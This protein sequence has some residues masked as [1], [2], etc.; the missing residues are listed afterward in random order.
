M[1]N[2]NKSWPADDTEY[3]FKN[4]GN[5]LFC[6]IYQKHPKHPKPKVRLIL[7]HLSMWVSEDS[8]SA[9]HHHSSWGTGS[10][11][12]LSP[13]QVTPA[14][15]IPIGIPAIRWPVVTPQGPSPPG[16]RASAARQ[17]PL[18][19]QTN[20]LTFLRRSFTLEIVSNRF[21]EDLKTGLTCRTGAQFTEPNHAAPWK[22]AHFIS[23]KCYSLYFIFTAVECWIK[24]D[25]LIWLI[26]KSTEGSMP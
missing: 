14:G 15:G 2:P 21:E 4:V 26:I 8:R 18:S 6:F 11:S 25:F 9:V 13:W 19:L 22:K 5:L 17:S 12:L 24:L 7:I 3:F 1:T 23:E 10:S 16:V 20:V